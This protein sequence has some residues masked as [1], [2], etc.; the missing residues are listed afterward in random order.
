MSHITLDEK[1]A[2]SMN[3]IHLFGHNSFIQGTSGVPMLLKED[4]RPS[5]SV[6]WE[7]VYANVTHAVYHFVFDNPVVVN[8]VRINPKNARTVRKTSAPLWLHKRMEALRQMPQPSL[9]ESLSQ[10][11]ALGEARRKLGN[12]REI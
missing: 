5:I 12:N 8:W 1:E 7:R 2:Q 6:G 3:R 10:W 9:K 4:A 11:R